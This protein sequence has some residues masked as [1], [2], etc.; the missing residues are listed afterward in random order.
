MSRVENFSRRGFLKLVGAGAVGA[1]VGAGANE[2]W[3]TSNSPQ[4]ERTPAP[5]PTPL[6]A[7]LSTKAE[8]ADINDK[9][10]QRH[11]AEVQT[12]DAE[13]N[14]SF[15]GRVVTRLID[16]A[17]IFLTGAGL[18]LGY[19]SERRKQQ[20]DAADEQTRRFEAQLAEITTRLDD[21]DLSTKLTAA[22]DVKK[23]AVSEN[24]QDLEGAFNICVK[25]LQK[26]DRGTSADDFYRS[27]T[28]SFFTS[29]SSL[30]KIKRTEI[31]KQKRIHESDRDHKA[32]F[33][34]VFDASGIYLKGIGVDKEG[35]IDRR[36][37]D[38]T[39]L[40]L[41]GATIDGSTLPKADFRGVS[42]R[43]V[44]FDDTNLQGADFRTA[45][46]DGSRF[47]GSGNP[48]AHTS[49]LEGTQFDAAS[50]DGVKIF[51]P[52]TPGLT[53]THLGLTPEQIQDMQNRG[54]MFDFSPPDSI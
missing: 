4:S 21:D 46:L 42:G 35:N 7:P 29:L 8:I 51:Y 53:V 36:P 38:F 33:A 17:P 23:L 49:N 54:V 25:Q 9:N 11:L 37:R 47:V 14:S 5:M 24:K 16:A 30:R 2:A 31:R 52:Q 26:F 15:G 20:G 39:N 40:I 45:T 41:D 12:A 32:L 19:Q 10:A 18:Y 34:P 6:E 1:V 50:L 22:K 28:D 48:L 43:E 3:R 13:R 44:I 27:I